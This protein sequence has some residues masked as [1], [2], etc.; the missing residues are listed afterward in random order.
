MCVSTKSSIGPGS[1]PRTVAYKIKMLSVKYIYKKQSIKKWM[2]LKKNLT[3][4]FTCENER[5]G[6]AGV[7]DN[8]TMNLSAPVPITEL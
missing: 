6:A 4:L 8:I 1:C 3:I 7:R 5:N 2:Q